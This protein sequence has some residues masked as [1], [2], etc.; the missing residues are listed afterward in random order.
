MCK[1]QAHIAQMSLELADTGAKDCNTH[2]TAILYIFLLYQ[3][4]DDL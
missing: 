1:Y 2:K 3:H 4:N